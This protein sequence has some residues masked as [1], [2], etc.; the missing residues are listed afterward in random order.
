METL[1]GT[2]PD[3]AGYNPGAIIPNAGGIPVTD[4]DQK[5]RQ[6]ANRL[7]LAEDLSAGIYQQYRGDEWH[8][9]SAP[10]GRRSVCF[11]GAA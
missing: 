10:D 2:C 5:T 4:N 8:G 1:R 7:R 3:A 11:G 6:Q 9:P